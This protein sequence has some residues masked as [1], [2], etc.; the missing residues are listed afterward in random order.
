[1]VMRPLCGVRA[2]A[3]PVTL[4]CGKFLVKLSLSHTHT[5]S[6]SQA[7]PAP[8]PVCVGSLFLRSVSRSHGNHDVTRRD[9]PPASPA[10]PDV[11]VS[12]PGDVEECQNQC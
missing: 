10:R 6:L 12:R 3:T 2:R 5:L 8:P 1:M 7:L 4:R 11:R 9:G